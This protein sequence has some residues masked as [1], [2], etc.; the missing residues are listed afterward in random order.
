MSR[1]INIFMKCAQ[2]TQ[3]YALKICVLS[4]SYSPLVVGVDVDLQQNHRGAKI[5]FVF[6]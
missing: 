6:R 2:L 1:F 4:E 3:L 5:I